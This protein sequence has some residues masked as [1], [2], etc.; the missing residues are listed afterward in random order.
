MKID[1]L[2][3]A[4]F[5]TQQWKNGGGSTLELYK[6]PNHGDYDI[7][8]SI[9]TVSAS[10]PFSKFPGYLRTIIQLEGVPMNLRHPD[11]GQSKVL[12]R[13]SPYLFDGEAVTDCDVI[14]SARDFNIIYKKTS[15][16]ETSVMT[17]QAHEKSILP[18]NASRS[19]V[20][21]VEGSIMAANLEIDSSLISENELCILTRGEA[22]KQVVMT[23]GNDGATLIVVLQN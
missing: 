15:T 20:F 1:L 12:E 8:L 23:A 10:G 9:A 14:G 6:H 18:G 16:V 7:R 13:H 21:C 4:Q 17:L 5:K 2:G 19:F 3:P 22:S 11:L